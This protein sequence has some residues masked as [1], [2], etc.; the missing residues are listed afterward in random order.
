M[1]L[2]HLQILFAN[3]CW[4]AE[5]TRKQV[6]AEAALNALLVIAKQ[7]TCS[8][9]YSSAW[10]LPAQEFWGWWGVWLSNANASGCW[11]SCGFAL[12]GGVRSCP[13]NYLVALSL[14]CFLS[15]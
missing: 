8:I 4:A 1:A 10:C 12:D 13:R 5:K 3:G 2:N 7:A 11:A 9:A 6:I 14:L 15:R